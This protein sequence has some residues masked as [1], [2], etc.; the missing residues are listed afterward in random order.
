MKIYLQI[1]EKPDIILNSCMNLFVMVMPRKLIGTAIETEL[2]SRSYCDNLFNATLL[3]RSY[4]TSIIK[5]L[6]AP[7]Q[8][9]HTGIDDIKIKVPKVRGSQR[10]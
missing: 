8:V 4:I 6:F 7:L 2:D 1:F 3:M 9:I 5:R 10:Q